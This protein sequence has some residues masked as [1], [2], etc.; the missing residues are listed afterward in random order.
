MESLTTKDAAARLGVPVSTFHRKYAPKLNPIW[1][2]PGLR[3][4]R[5]WNGAD[6]ARLIAE[7]DGDGEVA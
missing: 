5:L 2:A 6:I 4:A 7:R 1:K 3:G